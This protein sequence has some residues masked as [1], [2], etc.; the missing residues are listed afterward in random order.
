M[1]YDNQIK[2]YSND[3]VLIFKGKKP[4]FVSLKEF[5]RL[6]HEG[7]VE[8]YQY[9]LSAYWKYKRKCW[10]L[11]NILKKVERVKSLFTTVQS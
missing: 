7:R 2:S 3:K 1:F 8:P 4:I 5:D 9:A 6:L 11:K 10:T